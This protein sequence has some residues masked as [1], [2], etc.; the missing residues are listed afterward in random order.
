MTSE[1]K[2]DLLRNATN[3]PCCGEEGLVKFVENLL[4]KER[5]LGYDTG[6]DATKNVVTFRLGKETA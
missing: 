2:S 5:Q 4:K 3:I 6:W 1:E